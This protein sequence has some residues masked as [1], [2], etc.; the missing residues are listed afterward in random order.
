M[1]NMISELKRQIDENVAAERQKLRELH[2][3]NVTNFR[4]QHDRFIRETNGDN[5]KSLP[6][7]GAK[8]N[9][10]YVSDV[11]N[12]T[13]MWQNRQPQHTLVHQPVTSFNIYKPY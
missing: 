4:E 5:W 9:L 6:S 1:S 2:E 12:F 13:E 3:R 7:S 10:K 11:I 8:L